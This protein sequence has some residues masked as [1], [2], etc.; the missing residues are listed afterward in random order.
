MTYEDCELLPGS[1]VLDDC[2]WAYQKDEDGLWY[3]ARGWEGPIL[4]QHIRN[5]TLLLPAQK[6]V[7]KAN[8]A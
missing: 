4:F 5:P 3:I 8:E 6:A 2:G 1:V 7:A